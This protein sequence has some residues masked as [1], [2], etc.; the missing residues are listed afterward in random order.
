MLMFAAMSGKEKSI[1]IARLDLYQ[2]Y[3]NQGMRCIRE[4]INQ[5]SEVNELD[6]ILDEFDV[7]QKLSL[8]D[9]SYDLYISSGGPG[10]PLESIEEEWDIQYMEWLKNMLLY[11]NNTE[12]EIKKR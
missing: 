8:P 9:F 1:R 7:R 4:I 12:N 10:S 11:N 2:G 3:E 6:V 5:W